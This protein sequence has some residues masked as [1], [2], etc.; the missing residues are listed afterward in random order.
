[1]KKSHN[2]VFLPM[3]NQSNCAPLGCV[4]VL[5]IFEQSTAA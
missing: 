2:A 1:M 4:Q 5:N 3:V